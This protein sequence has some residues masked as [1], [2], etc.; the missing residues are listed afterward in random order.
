MGKDI[1]SAIERTYQA[2]RKI[3][4]MGSIIEQTSD[5]KALTHECRAFSAKA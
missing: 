3:P 2:V 5:W 1:P 4:G